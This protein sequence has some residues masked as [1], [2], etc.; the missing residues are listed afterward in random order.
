MWYKYVSFC[1]FSENVF[2]FWACTL[3]IMEQNTTACRRQKSSCL[4]SLVKVGG[5]TALIGDPSGK[6]SERPVLDVGEVESNVKRLEATLQRIF[7]NHER[8]LWK[9]Q[10]KLLP[11]KWVGHCLIFSKSLSAWKPSITNV[12]DLVVPCQCSK[13]QK[14]IHFSS[15][16]S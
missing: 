15:W 7:T 2:H 14:E 11:I 8:L 4:C 6:F 16:I 10:K 9:K 3:A 1:C 13:I 12:K 5:A